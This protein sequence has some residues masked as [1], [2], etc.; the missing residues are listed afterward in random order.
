MDMDRLSW[1]I[2]T[3]HVRKHICERVRDAKGSVLTIRPKHISRR[4]GIYA[5]AYM[6]LITHAI[7][8]FLNGAVL[9]VRRRSEKRRD[10]IIMIDVK[11]ARELCHQ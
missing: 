10:T 5:P 3:E 11:K 1:T 4:L 6:S 7:L 9:Q 2:I 8:E